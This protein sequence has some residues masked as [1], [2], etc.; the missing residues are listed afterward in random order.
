MRYSTVTATA[1]VYGA[2]HLPLIF[3]SYVRVLRETDRAG[4][5]MPQEESR[6]VEMPMA[7]PTD[8]HTSLNV[9]SEFPMHVH[10]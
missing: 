4:S 3:I 10:G 8:Y 2:V 9:G 5:A 6:I 1:T 7:E